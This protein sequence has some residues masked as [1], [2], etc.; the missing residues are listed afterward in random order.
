LADAAADAPSDQEA[1]PMKKSQL[2]LIAVAVAA[3][4]VV[5]SGGGKDDAPARAPRA[6]RRTSSASST[7]GDELG[8]PA[9]GM[10]EAFEETEPAAPP[11]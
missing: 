2:A 4:A 9:S 8:A 6:P 7:R 5:F 3:V 10:S 1:S 11:A